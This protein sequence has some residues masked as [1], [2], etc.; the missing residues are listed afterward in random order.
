MDIY[1]RFNLNHNSILKK[2]L[3]ILLISLGL[4]GCSVTEPVHLK[5]ASHQ[6]KKFI[7]PP[8]GKS[9]IYIYRNSF[10][11]AAVNRSVWIDNECV[12][13]IENG[14]FLYHEV[15]ADKDYTI[16]TETESSPYELVVNMKSGKIY[17]VE[18]K[19]R[20]GILKANSII[21][22]I[23]EKQAMPKVVLLSMGIKGDCT[24]VDWLSESL[25]LY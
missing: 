4:I 9:A 2:L 17:F 1:N 21:E 6:A 5:T 10:V 12:G 8:V 7:A 24:I 3:L 14:V 22:L 15:D 16:Y 25:Y 20:F 18:Q 13:K 23:D 19:I 11:G